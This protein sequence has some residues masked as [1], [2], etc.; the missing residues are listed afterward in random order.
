MNPFRSQARGRLSGD[1]VDT[2]V[3]WSLRAA[4]EATEPSDAVWQRIAAGARAERLRPAATRRAFERVQVSFESLT[5]FGGLG[6]LLHFMA[7]RMFRRR[8]AFQ[9]APWRT[10]YYRSAVSGPS[11]VWFAFSPPDLLAFGARLSAGRMV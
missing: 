11:M 4:V 3:R 9:D 6:A 8:A 1:D 2:L 7:D 10:D 5:S